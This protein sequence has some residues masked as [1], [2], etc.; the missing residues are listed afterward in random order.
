MDHYTLY[1]MRVRYSNRKFGSDQSIMKGT[2][3]GQ[4]ILYLYFSFY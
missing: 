2:L 3:F 4:Q 1:F